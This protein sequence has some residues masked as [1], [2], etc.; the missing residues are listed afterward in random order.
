MALSCLTLPAQQPAAPLTADQLKSQAMDAYT[1]KHY[2]DSIRLFQQALAIAQPGDRSDIE[3]D[4]AC[5]LALN[6]DKDRAFEVLTQSIDDGFGDRHQLTTDTDLPSLRTD[7]RWTALLDH[8]DAI[9]KAQDMR[10]GAQTFKTA[11]A[12]NLSDA[13]KAAGLSLL[14][15]QAR[16]GF[17]NFWHVPDLDWDATYQS[18]LPQVL[19]T[20][21][22]AEYYRVLR[23]FYALLHDGHT[24]VY[25]PE[26]LRTRSVPF[27]TRL[28]DGHVLVIGPYDAKFDMQG[29]K[30]GDELISIN[31]QPVKEWAQEKVAPYVSASSP[32][33]RDER[34]Y[35]RE[36]MRGT[37]GAVFHL[38]LRTPA[39]AESSHDFTVGSHDPAAR[40][41]FRML[42]GEIA[43]VALNEFED[44]TDADE[45][46]K[47]WPEIAKAKA[48]ILDLRRNGGGDDGVGAHILATLIDKPVAG[49][50]QESPEWIAT[51]RAWGQAEPTLRYPGNTLAP[52]A[53]HHFAGKVV[54]LTSANTFSAAEDA[55]VLFRTSQRGLIVGEP[56]GGS[57]GQPLSFNLPGG[58]S[59]RVCSKHDSFPDGHEFVG[60]GV[61]PDIQAHITREDLIHGT[62]SVLNA[63]VK[64]ALN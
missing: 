57:T 53:A 46:D 52:D 45:W 8:L 32:Q 19:A 58:G 51:Y 25:E 3:Y 12:D 31:G 27:Q 6:G 34:I 39:G 23:R 7:P 43:Y 15:A 9:K 21:S 47:H 1:A 29:V 33:D 28:I 18:Y 48:V 24:N 50:R 26:P 56:S 14:W 61:A 16:F 2:A 41:E 38:V 13:D 59:A 62:D 44:S 20:H 37:P 35:Y 22:T 36:L 5:S 40:F 10:W 55:V 64:A 17:A 4:E 63:A 49:S 60:V 11:Y 42:P 54:M 30:P